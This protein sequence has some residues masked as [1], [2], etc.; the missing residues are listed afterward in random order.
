[1]RGEQ[2]DIPVRLTV[3]YS[4]FHTPPLGRNPST[5]KDMQLGIFTYHKPHTQYAIP[6]ATWN[7]YLVQ[8][9]MTQQ[10]AGDSGIHGVI[11]RYRVDCSVVYFQSGD[12][13][14]VV[15]TAHNLRRI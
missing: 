2:A 11:L 5:R 12:M 1:M 14:S 7:I 9:C 13:S 10:S 6:W 4:R 15:S 8:Y 3:H